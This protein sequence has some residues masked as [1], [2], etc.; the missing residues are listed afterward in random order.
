MAL[1]VALPACLRN[2]K[3]FWWRT[4]QAADMGGEDA[5]GTVLH[6]NRYA[7]REL[8]KHCMSEI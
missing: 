1:P 6:A 4:D 3:S 2:R 8:Q 7:R 5:I